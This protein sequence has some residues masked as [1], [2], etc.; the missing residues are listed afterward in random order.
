MARPRAEQ[1]GLLLGHNVLTPI[2]AQPSSAGPDSPMQAGAAAGAP[3]ATPEVAPSK[4]LHSFDANPLQSLNQIAHVPSPTMELFRQLEESHV[5][6]VVVG[7]GPE[8]GA[9]EKSCLEF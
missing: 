4:E 5:E 9:G 7:D 1:N 3:A 2:A 6:D 8:D